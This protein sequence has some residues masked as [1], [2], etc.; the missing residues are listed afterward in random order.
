MPTPGR[1]IF[2]LRRF[3]WERCHSNAVILRSRASSRASRR[4]DHMRGLSSFEARK[5]SHLRTTTVLSPERA[6]GVDIER[7]DRLA[8]GH[9]K[10]GAVSAARTKDGGAPRQ[11]HA[12]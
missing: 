12:A 6:L 2:P 1:E 11:R 4:M 9:E 5:R 8:R 10:P 7:V 3:V